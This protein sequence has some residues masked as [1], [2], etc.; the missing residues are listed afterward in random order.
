MSRHLLVAAAQRR[1]LSCSRSRR[2]NKQ[3]NSGHGWSLNKRVYFSAKRR[4]SI[5]PELTSALVLHTR[6]E[7]AEIL[8]AR[9]AAVAHGS[10][11][12]H[13][14]TALQR[15]ARY[16]HAEC[17]SRTMWLGMEPRR[18]TPLGKSLSFTRLSS[19]S[20]GTTH[21]SPIASWDAI[22]RLL[23]ETLLKEPG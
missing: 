17:Y 22:S 12:L 4:L 21:S 3:T 9:T 13:A 16:S 11:F 23:T 2:G 8:N 1:A 6:R 19:M 5:V 18:R 15:S 10:A 14:S 20:H 7:D